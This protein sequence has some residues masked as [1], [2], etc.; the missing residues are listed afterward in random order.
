MSLSLAEEEI[1]SPYTKN[2]INAAIS[3]GPVQLSWWSAG[4]TTVRW[5]VRITEVPPKVYDDARATNGPR[6]QDP[7]NSTKNLKTKLDRIPTAKT[8]KNSSNAFLGPNCLEV[9]IN[10]LLT[11]ANG[12]GGANPNREHCLHQI[13]A[14]KKQGESE[15]L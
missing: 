14:A 11:R 4:L 15:R 6:G 13:A 7:R 8:K 1:N 12:G 2:T 5:W 3:A 10:L 9:K